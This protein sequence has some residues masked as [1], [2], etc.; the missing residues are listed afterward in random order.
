MFEDYTVAVKVKLFNEVSGGLMLMSRQFEGLTD[1]ALI[2]QGHIKKIQGLMTAGFGMIAGGA[3]LAT[4]F[5]YAISKAAELQKQMIGIQVATHGTTGQMDSLRV[6]IEKASAPT[7]FSALD[8]AK[9]AKSV[10]T[11]NSFNATQL[12]ALMPAIAKFADVQYLM[13]GTSYSSSVVDAVKMMHLAQKYS[14]KD[15]EP[16]FDAITK[17]SFMMPGGAGELRSALSYFQ[18]AGKAALGVTDTDAL[19]L[20]ALLSRLGLSGSRGGT[21][22]LAA[23]SRTI[24]GVFGSGLLKGK[25]HEALADMGF[26]DKN[27]HSKFM[28]NGKFS[29]EQWVYGLSE[30]I[31]SALAKDPLHGRER[32]MTDYQHAFGTQGGKVAGLLSMPGAIDQL[33][34]MGED[35][36]KLASMGKI[37][38]NFVQESVAQQYQTAVT[39]FQNAMIELGYNLL[40]LATHAL[41]DI[42]AALDTI[43]PWMRTHK[44]LVKELS[45]AFLVLAGT[46]AIAGLVSTLAA[47][48]TVLSGALK[49]ILAV[50]G[51][52]ATSAGL[53]GAG[54]GVAARTAAM[55][56]TI[57]GV[58]VAG[59]TGYQIGNFLNRTFNLPELIGG[60]IYRATHPDQDNAYASSP[61]SSLTRRDNSQQIVIQV[62]GR[63]LM[64]ALLPSLNQ[65]LY[66]AQVQQSNGFMTSMTPIQPNTGVPFR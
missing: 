18:P 65:S 38:N 51:I 4:P 13:K 59:Y 56:T 53:A 55:A 12:Q 42:N 9:M 44:K 46:M 39:N 20:V 63:N 6:A 22:L 11:S 49:G 3:A 31:R 40:P 37:Q 1:K 54:A 52:S 30:F 16:Y 2:F 21:N 7:V 8:V 10:A 32:I 64:T 58:A 45:E 15:V 43:I 5:V 36:Y 28:V 48:F 41:N 24:P 57:G 47:T 60:G 66:H 23:M 25:S 35:F 26:I 19:M 17:V 29:T 50:T 33:A 34:A 27:G 62:D 61:P 14:P